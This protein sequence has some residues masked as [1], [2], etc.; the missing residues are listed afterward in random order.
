MVESSTQIH[1]E[2]ALGEMQA[3]ISDSTQDYAFGAF[4]VAGCEHG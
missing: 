1:L 2:N 4:S 3:I